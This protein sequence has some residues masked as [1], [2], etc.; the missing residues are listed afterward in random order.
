MN[1]E[2]TQPYIDMSSSPLN[3][4][5]VQAGGRHICKSLGRACFLCFLV[6][7]CVYPVVYMQK[8]SDKGF[9]VLL[10]D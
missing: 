1:S 4:S 5:P 7:Q 3:S 6:S 9:Q 8:A 2:E 10:G